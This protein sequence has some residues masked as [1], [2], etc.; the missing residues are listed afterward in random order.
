MHNDFWKQLKSGTDVRG[1][2]SE[3][4]PGQSVNLTDEAVG[5]ITGAYVLWLTEKTGKEAGKLTVAVG[6]DSR[7]SGRC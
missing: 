4:I 3:G 2:A 5:K 1:V 7:I 6:R